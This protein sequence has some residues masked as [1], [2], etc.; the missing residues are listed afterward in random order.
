M[1]LR[2]LLEDYDFNELMPV[3][4]DMFPG[5]GKYREPLR[6]AYDMLLKTRTTSSNKVIR[7][8]IL[9]DEKGGHSY[10]GA[11][12]KDF[13]STWDVCL[14][15]E[16]VR[17]KGVDLSNIELAANSLINLCLISHYPPAFEP[18]HEQLTK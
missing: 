3:I 1:R 14:G 2:N 18:I 13:K 10:M 9:R 4:A 6:Q 12:D 17:E 16:V 7:Y 11:E 8:K 5:T 15:K